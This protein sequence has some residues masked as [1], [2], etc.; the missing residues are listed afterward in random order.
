[1]IV[2][3]TTLCA[4][5]MDDPDT[6]GSWLKNAEK[7][8]ELGVEARGEPVHFFAAIE[9]DARGIEPF[10]PLVDRLAEIGADYWTFTLDDGRTSVTTANRLRHITMGQN[11]C[12]DFCST[13]GIDWMLFLAADCRPPADAVERLL[14]VKHPL[15][16]GHVPTYCLEG[17]LVIGYPLEWDVQAHMP[18]AAFVMIH[19]KIYT[20]LRW[21][22]DAVNGMSDDPAYH[23]DAATLM[24]TDAY[25]RHDVIGRHFPETI[26]A[27]ETRGHDM[28]VHRDESPGLEPKT[29][30]DESHTF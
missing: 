26:G 17:K 30:I 16:G 21:R 1:M 28:T 5:A 8:R 15:V 27:V 22:W 24:H 7:M 9:L 23:Y 13:P 20:R 4:F 18:T 6:W 10:K 3:A 29:L 11:L 19:R 2:A 12:T 14:E 25:V